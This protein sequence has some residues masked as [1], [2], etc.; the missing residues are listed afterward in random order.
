M[1][2]C[3][4]C[5]EKFEGSANRR[6][7]NIKCEYAYLQKKKIPQFANLTECPLLIACNRATSI[8]CSDRED[9]RSCDLLK[10]C[11]IE[12]RNQKARA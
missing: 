5:N 1:P 2:V 10:S 9:W 7:C 8:D 11:V 6:Y 3:A 4:V 12:K